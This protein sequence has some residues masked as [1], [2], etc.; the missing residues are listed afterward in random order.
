MNTNQKINSTELSAGNDIAAIRQVVTLQDLR[1]ADV[2]CGAGKLAMALAEAGAEVIAI[3][4]DAAQAAKNRDNL[5]LPGITFAEAR[6]EA[7]PCRDAE[8]DG[9]FYCRSLHHVPPAAMDAALE[10]AARVLSPARGFLC[11]I[12]PDMS[13]KWW[14]LQ[15]LH[16]DESEVRRLALEALDRTAVKLFNH[17]AEYWYTVN[18]SYADFET[19]LARQKAVTFRDPNGALLARAEVEQ[20]FEDGRADD[21]YVFGQPM[22][23]RVYENRAREAGNE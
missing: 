11:V 14:A 18:I 7:I 19:Y 16:A 8:I 9:V 21:G 2:G 10:E 1:V 4:P 13:G 15:R 20:R 17:C 5:R 22:R 6:A 12:E 3:E 23:M